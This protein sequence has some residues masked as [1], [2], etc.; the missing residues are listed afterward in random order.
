MVALARIEKCLIFKNYKL[1]HGKTTH[2]LFFHRI[3]MIERGRE[4]SAIEKEKRDTGGARR[5]KRE[6][7]GAK[8]ERERERE[9]EVREARWLCYREAEC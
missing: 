8:R 5:S 9:R 6:V 4:R 2:I 1:L 3:K 7:V